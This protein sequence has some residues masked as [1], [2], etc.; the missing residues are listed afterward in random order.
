MLH[1]FASKEALL[2][3]V[4]DRLE[5]HAQEALDRADGLAVDST[6]M[7]NSLMEIWHPASHT[8]QLLAMLTTD[9][10]SEDHPGRYRMSR[11]RR[12]HEHILEKCFAQLAENGQMRAG[13]DPPFAGRAF[14][15]L[16]LGHAVR[17]KTVRAMQKELHHDSPLEDL[18]KLLR[19]FLQPAL[20][21]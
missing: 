19:A 17:E 13:I 9:A 2:D 12:V 8:M 3:A 1:H 21:N 5:T 7:L 20:E 10:V 6:A 14:M 18:A 15:D 16:V 11:L 4:I